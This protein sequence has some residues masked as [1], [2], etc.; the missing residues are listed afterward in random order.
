MLLGHALASG[1]SGILSLILRESRPSLSSL[2][3]PL[4]PE[5]DEALKLRF[6]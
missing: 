5:T 4:L 1:G 6:V 3:S 2:L